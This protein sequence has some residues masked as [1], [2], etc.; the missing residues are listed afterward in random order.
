MFFSFNDAKLYSFYF[1]H[2]SLMQTWCCSY[3]LCTKSHWPLLTSQ[4]TQKRLER[5]SHFA[6]V[7][8]VRE[9]AQDRSGGGRQAVQGTEPC[10]ALLECKD[11]RASLRGSR[12]RDLYLWTFITIVFITHRNRQLCCPSI[13]F[14]VFVVY[15]FPFFVCKKVAGLEQR[16]NKKEEKEKAYWGA[17][18]Y[19]N[20]KKPHPKLTDKCLDI[21][22]ARRW[23]WWGQVIWVEAQCFVLRGFNHSQE[24]KALHQNGGDI[25]VINVIKVQPSNIHSKN[26]LSKNITTFSTIVLK[27]LTANT[28]MRNDMILSNLKWLLNCTW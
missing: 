19:K 13:F 17:T 11:T 21:G 20:L 5:Q 26:L 15:F 9:C 25:K 12:A 18:H 23:A 1:F 3:L 7:K 14:N 24:R 2:S 4:L 6:K 8:W 16:K 10:P 27:Y 28:L 22:M